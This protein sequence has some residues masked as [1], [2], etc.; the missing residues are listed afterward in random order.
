[1]MTRRS[2]FEALAAGSLAASGTS[3]RG[4]TAAAMGGATAASGCGEAALSG[5]GTV[6][7]GGCGPDPC[8]AADTTGARG[9]GRIGVGL[10]VAV[11]P[12]SR[13]SASWMPRG[14]GWSR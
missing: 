4:G 6:A 10:S 9:A 3:A 11:P 5:C 13:F 2:A 1:M 14:L 12:G 7:E 8:S